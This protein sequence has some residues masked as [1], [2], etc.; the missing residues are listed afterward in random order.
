MK[1]LT[2][3]FIGLFVSLIT[4]AGEVTE[5]QALQKAQQFMQGKQFKQKN[6]RRAPSTASKAY[7]VFNAENNG[8]FVI[9]SGDDRTPEILG[10]AEKGRLMPAT[11]P[12]NVKAWL[13]YC[14]KII[15]DLNQHEGQHAPTIVHEIKPEVSPM[16]STLWGQG[17]PYNGQCPQV[18]GENCVTGCVA[19]AMAQIINYNRWPQSETSA[20]GAYYTSSYHF[21]LEQLEPTSFNWDNMTSSDI[22]R[23]MRYCGQTVRMDYGP[24]ESGAD[25]N[26]IVPAL[27]GVF[28]YSKV[29]QLKERSNYSSDEWDE[30]IYEELAAGRPVI[31]NGW[32]NV[33]GHTFV[34]DGY[35]DAFF[36]VNWGWDGDCNGYFTLTN[37]SPYEDVQ[38]SDTQSAVVGIQSLGSSSDVSRP[39]AVVT[40]M[41][42]SDEKV[43][44]ESVENDFPQVTLRSMVESDMADAATLQIGLGLYDENGLMKVLGSDE[45]AF[46]VGDRYTYETT[47]VFG[48]DLPAGTYYVKAI[49][50]MNDTEAWLSDAGSSDRYVKVLITDAS[51]KLQPY[52]RTGWNEYTEDMGIYTIDGVTYQLYYEFGYYHAMILPYKETQHYAGDIYIPSTV[53]YAGNDYQINNCDWKAFMDCEELTSLSTQFG[54]SVINCPKLNHL[55]LREGLVSW[56]GDLSGCAIE[57]ITYPSTLAKVILPGSCTQ[58]KTIIFKTTTQLTFNGIPAVTEESMPALTDIYFASDLPPVIN[59]VTRQNIPASSKVVVH[60]PQGSVEAY[61][62]SE[63]KDFVFSED[64]PAIPVSVKWDY[65]GNDENAFYGCGMGWGDNEVEFAMRVPAEQI[66]AYKGCTINSI[67]FYTPIPAINAAANENIEYV[68]ITKRGTDYLVKQPIDLI[69]GTWTTVILP[70]PY[71]ITGE[72]LFVGIGRHGAL[73]VN[74]ANTESNPDVQWYR[75]MGT[76]D[77]WGTPGEWY[78][79]SIFEGWGH[80]MPLRFVIQGDQLP[81][82]LIVENLSIVGGDAGEEQTQ[83]APLNT[84]DAQQL[85]NGKYYCMTR[86]SKGDC[87][88]V[89]K[90]ARPAKKTIRRA[91]SGDSLVQMK[92][93]LRSRTPRV[94]KS[95]T[96]DWRIDEIAT[97]KQTVETTLLPN[98]RE[99]VTIDLPSTIKGRNHSILV[100]VADI[101]GEPDGVAANS[102]ET[103]EFVTP[104]TTHYPRRI[105]MEE[106]TGTWCGWCPRGIQ[107][108]KMM[109]EEYPDNFI[110][111]AVHGGDVMQTAD[112]SYDAL[113]E[114]MATF[115]NS[116]INRQYQMDPYHYDVWMTFLKIGTEA[117][118][119]IEAQALFTSRD[120]S[121]VSIRTETTFGF[122]DEGKYSIAYVVV[123]DSVGPYIQNNYYS[124]PSVPDDPG[125]WLND[126]FHKDAAVGMLFNDVAR[127]IYGDYQGTEGSVPSVV[128]EN[129]AYEYVYSFKL[130]NNIQNKKN[131]RIVTLLIDNSSG[132]IMNADQTTIDYDTSKIT[133]IRVK[134]YQREYG[135]SNPVFEY[136]I[137]G[138]FLEGAPVLGCE[139]TESSPVGTYPITVSQGTVT[140]EFIDCVNG[141]LTIEK[142][143]LTITAKDYTIKQGEALPTFEA[144][145][146][147][148]KNNETS[149]VLTKQP[150][151]STTA[152]SACEPGEYEIT[153]SG[154]EAQ[155][156][157]MSY[158][159]GKL[160]IEEQSIDLT[161]S[162]GQQW[163]TF[164][165]GTPCKLSKDSNAKVYAV[166]N[167]DNE[168]VY[169][170]ECLNGIPANCMVLVGLVSKPEEPNTVMFDY[171]D[172]TSS[173]STL[174]M[175]GVSETTGLTP[176]STYVLYNDEFVL[177]SGTSV[178]AG[179][180]YLAKPSNEARHY[181]DIVIDGGATSVQNLTRLPNHT[182]TWFDLQGRKLSGYPTKNGIYLNNS[183]KI[184][185]K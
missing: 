84:K 180:G 109:A 31:Y 110:G 29:A 93:T 169:I 124:N 132:E 25:V 52:P 164:I 3:L 120:S 90:S 57:E 76:D 181:L 17:F 158:V 179:K 116:L 155:N 44:R 39:K 59:D 122:D 23:L 167:I 14:S 21:S 143:P 150:V 177:N 178:A 112:H 38:F 74:F 82:D 176:Y 106:A 85:T 159:A 19:T 16:V 161:F 11:A 94:V 165:S 41:E 63:W 12:C 83:A 27:T 71:T 61:K 182:D 170:E 183:K 101:D 64:Q 86:N 134:D 121:S 72:E 60:V 166:T 67:Q 136:T 142:A 129:K 10:Y 51:L 20:V 96:M 117:D 184:V 89:S 99:T 100:D 54:L 111:I 119:K 55:E 175:G 168:N 156:Y 56:T 95:V 92:A 135:E 40:L 144:T 115:P 103:T 28:G 172:Q 33:G 139:A 104:A 4:F 35:K 15:E 46:A 79:C 133:T 68:F 157:E 114:Q 47:A 9:V 141:T 26:Y 58:L 18:D 1:K 48:A 171:C 105:V 49:N 81:A 65:C 45:H 5:Q 131:I 42:A 7:Y 87:F 160:T 148:F 24:W 66:E 145:Y 108:M 22:A 34:V 149:D 53:N 30:L 43:F 2:L 69:R 146:E 118:A 130:P 75:G 70:E 107:T 127:G 73:G 140:G 152:T 138:T 154:A 80:P 147:G 97:G 91:A 78:P 98:H 128:E 102:T 173:I 36:Y 113:L 6:L 32:G 137:E 13:E 88:S 125:D 126:W 162:A 37:L 50:R 185:I 77:Y 62:Y 151:L 153:V 163:Q 123:E 8:G 174:L